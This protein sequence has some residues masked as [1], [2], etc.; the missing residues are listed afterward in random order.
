MLPWHKALKKR[1]KRE[2]RGQATFFLKKRG[3]QKKGTGYFFPELIGQ[4]LLSGSFINK[5]YKIKEGFV[6]A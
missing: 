2:K 5:G 6:Y 1:G 4:S 3:Q